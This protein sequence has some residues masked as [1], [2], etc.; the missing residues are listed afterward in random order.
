R[1]AS[2][3]GGGLRKPSRY[4]GGSGSASIGSATATIALRTPCSSKGSAGIAS[5]S[6]T[7]TPAAPRNAAEAGQET[8]NSKQRA[9]RKKSSRTKGAPRATQATSARLKE[10]WATAEFR[11]KMKQRDQ[12]RITAAKQNPAK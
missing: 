5:R 11:E 12:A 7:R 9:P 10:L 6:P 4:Q 3:N 1:E 2:M 8:M